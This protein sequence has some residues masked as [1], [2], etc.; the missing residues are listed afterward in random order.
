M[1]PPVA[2][3]ATTVRGYIGAL[4]RGNPD[5][6]VSYVS[7]EFV[8][9]HTS[10][11][12]ETVTGRGAYRTR[13]EDFLGQFRELH[14]EIEQTIA[15]G[16]QVAVAYRMSARYRDVGSGFA[17]DCPIQI[18]GMFRFRVEHG[19]IVHRVDYWD[20]AEFQRQVRSA[21]GLRP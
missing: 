6:I 11:L 20:S 21:A 15:E 2:D 10:A 12:G 19:R 18:R 3:A 7:D 9:E 13:L 14:Y 17:L 16:A 1:K 4:N 8:N 5:D